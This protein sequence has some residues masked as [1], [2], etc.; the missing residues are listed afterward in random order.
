MIILFT[1]A[2]QDARL[3]LAGFN[4]EYLDKDDFEV[5]EYNGKKCLAPEPYTFVK[6]E[7]KYCAMVLSSFIT[8]MTGNKRRMNDLGTMKFIVKD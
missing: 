8:R 2:D 5:W 7:A 3:K 4:F 1:K 6:T